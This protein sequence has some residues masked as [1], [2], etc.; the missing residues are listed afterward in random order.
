MS[1]RFIVIIKMIQKP[2]K[3][4]HARNTKT[5]DCGHDMRPSVQAPTVN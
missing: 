2:Y 3:L 5:T 4:Q 1:D